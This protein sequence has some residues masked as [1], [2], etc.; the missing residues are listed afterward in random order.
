MLGNQ[1]IT[2]LL[3]GDLL[4][5]LLS[6]RQ[7]FELK[8]NEKLF[9]EERDLDFY[10]KGEEIPLTDS[11]FWQVYRGI[12]QLNRF[13]GSEKEVVVGW[14]TPNHAFGNDING[15]SNYSAIALTDIY[16][17]YYQP[18]QVIRDIQL[19]RLLLSELSYR[20]LKSEQ[21][22]AITS[23]RKVEDRLLGLLSML[24]EEMGHPIVNGTRLTVRFTH[25]NI[26]DAVCTTRVTIT[27]I[28]GE[29]QNQNLLEFDSDRHLIVK[30]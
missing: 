5:M 26:A 12:V 23:L 4:L 27:R 18:Q 1:N 6:D 15:T 25:Q 9:Q 30:F 21:M 14:V 8:L 2:L 7:T 19:A 24:K 17:R 11:G 16:L 3:V 20:L 22:I 10:Q 13:N 28:L 29:L